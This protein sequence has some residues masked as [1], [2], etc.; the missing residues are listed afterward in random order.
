MCSVTGKTVQQIGITAART[1]CDITATLQSNAERHR[2]LASCW[3]EAF[4]VLISERPLVFV[5][6]DMGYK[7]FAFE[8]LYKAELDK[9]KQD[10]FLLCMSGCCSLHC[11]SCHQCATAEHSMNM[12]V[13][14]ASYCC[15]S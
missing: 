14:S 3:N 7:Q 10:T 4:L 8:D 5:C 9:L 15:S 13:I 11:Q 1:L 2:R 12:H 6:R